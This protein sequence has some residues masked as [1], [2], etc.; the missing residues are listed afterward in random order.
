[1]HP[2]IFGNTIGNA[3]AGGISSNQDTSAQGQGGGG[4]SSLNGPISNLGNVNLPNPYA[5]STNLSVSDVGAAGAAS[6]PVD[7]RTG[8][9]SVVPST[10]GASPATTYVSYTAVP[11]DGGG[12]GYV[13]TV[14]AGGANPGVIYFNDANLANQAVYETDAYQNGQFLSRQFG[15][16]YGG[17][18]LG[19]IPAS[20]TGQQT[21]AGLSFSWIPSSAM[22]QINDQ[23]IGYGGALGV[24]MDGAVTLGAGAIEDGVL[25]L[26]EGLADSAAIHAA[27][28]DQVLGGYAADQWGMTTLRA[29]DKVYGGLPGQSAYYTNADTLAASQG[30]RTSLFQSLQVAPH[31]EFGYRPLIGEYEVVGSARVPSGTVLA[32]PS[33]GTGG[34]SQLFIS[35]YANNLRLVR[36]IP[37]GQ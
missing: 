23:P 37:L 15:T 13:P 19:V 5:G 14:G 22:A 8:T 3:I 21:S 33:Y 26:G 2:D 20:A 30:S 36:Q 18:D 11:L 9:V 27:K 34:G 28:A 10:D 29:G 16:T 17:S 1:L 35:D 12:S 4:G 25:A 32:N 24:V 7:T 31:P 6:A